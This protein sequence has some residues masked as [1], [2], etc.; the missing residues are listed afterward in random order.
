VP[1]TSDRPSAADFY[2]RDVLPALASRLDEAFPEFGWR[3]DG[4]GWHAT[5]PA[6][7]HATL[8]VRADRV[9]CH[10]AAPR[11]FLIHG[12]GPI[13]WTTYVNQGRAARGRDFVDAVRAI[14]TRAG[15]DSWTLDRPPTPAERRARLLEHALAAAQRELL[16]ERGDTARTYLEHRGIPPEHT[17][18]TGLGVM[19][20]PDR[21]RIALTS[22]GYTEADIDASQLLADSRWPSRVVGAW[23]DPHD[24]IVT[25]W[26]RSIDRDDKTRYLYLRGTPRGAG[27]PYGLSPTSA[28]TVLTRTANS[29]SSRV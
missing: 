21:L 20:D 25:L 18:E 9:V 16:G 29:Y 22:K 14:A 12:E 6:F 27:I 11:G 7:T 10:G 5:N 2:E 24:R 26:A 28:D 23:R 1:T 8:G 15:I 19:P 3:R 13:L 4:R 17:T